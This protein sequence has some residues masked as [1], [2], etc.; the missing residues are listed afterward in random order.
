VHLV[1]VCLFAVIHSLA[2]ARYRFWSFLVHRV[3]ILRE[4][5]PVMS[6]VKRAPVRL[7]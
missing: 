5:M 4:L 1:H 6:L 3:V 7:I 2:N